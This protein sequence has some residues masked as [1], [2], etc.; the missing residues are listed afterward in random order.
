MSSHTA[1]SPLLKVTCWGKVQVTLLC[2]SLAACGP[3]QTVPVSR[4]LYCRPQRSLPSLLVPPKGCKQ[5]RNAAGLFLMS[6][7]TSYRMYYVLCTVSSR[8]EACAG[9]DVMMVD[10]ARIYQ[11]KLERYHTR[12]ARSKCQGSVGISGFRKQGWGW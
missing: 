8:C 6:P 9:W 7:M 1:S 11:V 3:E 10:S 12:Y 2:L 4:G 5:V